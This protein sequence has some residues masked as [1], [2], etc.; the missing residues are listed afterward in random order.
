MEVV[1]GR[2]EGGLPPR[3][4]PPSASANSPEPIA[5]A[6]ARGPR[7]HMVQSPATAGTGCDV[8]GMTVLT[9]MEQ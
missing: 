8:A 2:G 5:P 1:R 7:V 4:T 6:S 3:S 9:R